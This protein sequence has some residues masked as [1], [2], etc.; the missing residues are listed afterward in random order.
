VKQYY[1]PGTI[2]KHCGLTLHPSGDQYCG[3]HLD[4]PLGSIKTPNWPEKDYPA[5]VTCSWHIVAPKNQVS[6]R[7]QPEGLTL[8]TVQLDTIDSD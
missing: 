7:L 3:G 2:T 1:L 8:L 4:K 5:G 6:V